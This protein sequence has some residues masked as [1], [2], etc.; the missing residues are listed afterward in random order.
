MEP[1]QNNQPV[2]SNNENSIG[3]VI[4]IIIVLLMVILGGVYF[5]GE[6]NNSAQPASQEVVVN[7]A[8]VDAV[9]GKIMQQSTS[10]ESASIEADLNGTDVDTVG[11]DLNNL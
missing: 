2:Q 10:D 8:N 11:A 9:S 4:A 3:P 1:N 5:W 6:R 7:E